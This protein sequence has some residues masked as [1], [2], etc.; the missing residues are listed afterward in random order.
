MWRQRFID[1]KFK[2]KKF[3]DKRLHF[4]FMVMTSE[5]MLKKT[6]EEHIKDF[7]ESTLKDKSRAD[8]NTNSGSNS[9]C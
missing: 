4:S 5:Y 3:R 6:P 2:D 9:H 8:N 7:Y 1:E